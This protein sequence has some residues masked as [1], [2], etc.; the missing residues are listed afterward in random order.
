MQEAQAFLADTGSGLPERKKLQVSLQ[1][2]VAAVF[3][4]SIT[5]NCRYILRIHICSSAPGG[6]TSS[7]N[8][9]KFSELFCLHHEVGTLKTSLLYARYAFFSPFCLL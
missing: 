8:P 6:S 9:R 5:Q 7:S 3:L 2:F 1:V 4:D